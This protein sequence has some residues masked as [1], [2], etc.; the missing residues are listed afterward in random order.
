MDRVRVLVGAYGQ[1][2]FP[3]L[4]FQFFVDMLRDKGFQVDLVFHTW[5]QTSSDSVAPWVD[6]KS[7]E[8]L[9]T[10][11]LVSQFKPIS[12]EETE[13]VPVPNPL[14]AL[15]ACQES[16]LCWNLT[17]MYFSMSRV[18]RLM[19][20]AGK[21]SNYDLY[22]V[23]RFDFRPETWELPPMSSETV[24]YPKLLT[25]TNDLCDWAF[26][27][28]PTALVKLADTNA[29]QAVIESVRSSGLVKG[30]Y[31]LRTYLSL[32]GL[33]ASDFRAGGYLVRDKNLR[34][35]WGQPDPRRHPLKYAVH[36]A[37][38]KFKLKLNAIDRT[39]MR[40]PELRNALRQIIRR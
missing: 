5:T 27:L 29:S 2:R 37:L 8:I 1:A 18:L 26:A 20:A 22:I 12:F 36:L 7:I 32:A 14:K 33:V 25:G 19:T 31:V 16:K 4:G 28:G 9:D 38:S 11:G 21:K 23:T 39:L 13:H 40:F 17:Q 10:E 6:A 34:I 15:G 24:F 35:S 3:L 30:E